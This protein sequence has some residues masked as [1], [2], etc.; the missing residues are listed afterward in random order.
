MLFTDRQPIQN[1]WL[2]RMQA[3]RRSFAFTLI[4]LLVVISIIA[5]LI[6]VLLPAL[7]SA[8]A[9]ARQVACLSSQRQIGL[10]AMNHANDRRERLPLAGLMP[11]ASQWPTEIVTYSDGGNAR[12]APLPV[13]IAGYIDH[14]V[15]LDSL[16]NVETDMDQGAARRLFTCPSDGGGRRVNLIQGGGWQGPWVWSS[17]AT[18]EGA[19]GWDTTGR[20]GRGDLKRIPK[21]SETLLLI[22]GLP[23]RVNPST[24]DDYLAMVANFVDATKTLLDVRTANQAGWVQ[25]LAFDRHNND[26]V[27]LLYLDGHASNLLLADT[28]ALIEVRITPE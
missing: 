11:A 14:S 16:A 20:R 22:D 10:A 1:H 17:Y 24:K 8:Q 21:P 23:R 28:N 12:V 9:A 3:N 5:L 19:L 13:A 18:N 6:A 7:S 25:A 26:A 27:N 4:E 15:R 2:N